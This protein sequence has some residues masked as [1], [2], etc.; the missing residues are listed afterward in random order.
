[1]R[2]PADDR[3]RVA[4]LRALLRARDTLARA[5]ELQR[6]AP[7][8]TSWLL[9]RFQDYLNV[10]R[11]DAATGILDRL[12]TELRL[13]ALNVKFLEVQL[14]AAF[15]DW[16]AIVDL[17]EFPNLCVARKAPAITAILLEVAAKGVTNLLGETRG[18]ALCPLSLGLSAKLRDHGRRQ[19]L[20]AE[21]PSRGLIAGESTSGH[22]S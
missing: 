12:R 20:F 6:S 15:D 4:A 9:A 3:A 21:S 5:P 7:V 13:D 17:P 16:A 22:Y 10:G 11:R 8:P 19:R 2:L 14:L 1:M 18:E